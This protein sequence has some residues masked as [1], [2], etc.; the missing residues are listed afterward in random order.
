LLKTGRHS[1]TALTRLGSKN[2]FPTGVKAVE[3][4]YDDEASIVEA[5][6]GQQ[7]LVI[8]IS[9]TAPPDLHEKIVKAGAKAGV[10]YIL[11]NVYGYDFENET[12]YKGDTYAKVSLSRLT[13]VTN[14]GV[15]YIGMVCGFWYE[16]SLGC[17]EPWFGFDIKKRTVTF[18]DEGKTAINVSTWQRCGQA[19]AALLSLPVD[20]KSPAVSDWKNK[21]FYLDSF[22]VS[23]RDMLDS[24]HR[25]LG[26]TDKDWE[27]SFEA[28]DAR[29][30]RG[31]EELKAGNREG[32]ARQLYANVFLPNGNGD[33]EAKGLVNGLLNLPKDDLDE[34]T[35]RTVEMVENGWTPFG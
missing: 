6:K 33:Y 3:V 10:P 21:P 35:K 24:L 22:K 4:N 14:A 9:V 17:G 15:P 29:F 12:L 1:V 8:T 28:S 32:F 19:L 30:Q 13:D 16:W 27:I 20:G 11:P 5:L 34:A 18:F 7:F 2:T 25:V 23:Q 31:V 26:T